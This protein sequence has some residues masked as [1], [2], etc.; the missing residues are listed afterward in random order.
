VPLG[1]AAPAFDVLQ[2]ED[3]DWI[4][5]GNASA[6]ARGVAAA[7][8]RLGYGAAD[9]HYF[10]GFVLTP[11]QSNEWQ[12]IDKA[13]QTGVLRGVA[14]TFVWALPQVLRD[15]FTA[16][17]QGDDD[18]Q[19]FDDVLFPLAIGKGATVAPRFST[20]IATSA[21]GREQRNADWASA[22]LD[23]DAGPGLRSEG[24]VQALIHFFRARRGAAKAFRFR[25]PIDH[26]ATDETLG[27][28]DGVRT[29]FALVKHYG[30]GPDAEE[31]R[32]ALPVIGTV[33][34]K[35]DGAET[36]AGWSVEEGAIAFALPPAPG[37]IITAS[38]AFD[39]P[40]RFAEDRLAI[41][42]D[43]FLA[44]SAASVPLVEV[45]AEDVLYG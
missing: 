32:I 41:D 33:I 35:I 44:G 24:D 30:E 14:E 31:R 11:Q 21:S 39:V 28:G 16:F 20:A 9:Q 26:Q 7:S 18:V 34:V 4:T 40:V 10:A 2:L 38:F 25:D 3:Y 23:F 6:S 37:T 12:H 43:T 5:T 13:A 19:A 42:C 17:P 1:W 22:R 45:R 36:L 27:T 8:A 15:G 29:A